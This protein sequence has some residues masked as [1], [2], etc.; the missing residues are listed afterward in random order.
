VTADQLELISTDPTG[1]YGRALTAG[2]CLP[3]G[4]ILDCVAA[5]YGSG[6]AREEL[7]PLPQSRRHHDER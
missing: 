3:V 2:T 6:L 5:T 1:G 7:L 4:A